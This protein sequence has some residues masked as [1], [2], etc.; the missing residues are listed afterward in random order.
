MSFQDPESE[1]SRFN[2]GEMDDGL[3][4]W[5]AEVLAAA[6]EV[7]LRSGGTFDAGCTGRGTDLSGI[8]KGFAVDRAVDDLKLAGVE[9]GIVNAGD[10][11]AVF[12]DSDVEVGVRDPAN[13]T[14]VAALVRLC[15]EALCSSGRAIDPRTRLPVPGNDGASVR[16]PTCTIADALTKVVGV[17]DASSLPLLRSFGAAALLFCDGRMV[18]LET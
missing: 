8:A 14:R 10:D 9:R 7:R 3:H 1:L 11:L 2:R 4:A 5:T 13:P 12:G 15:N 6:S 16:A 18:S 17:Q